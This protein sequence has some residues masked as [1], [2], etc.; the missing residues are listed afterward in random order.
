MTAKRSAGRDD[1][2]ALALLGKNLHHAARRVAVKRRK[3]SLEH[4]YSLGRPQINVRELALSVWQGRGNTI[5]IHTQA[6]HTKSRACAKAAYGQLQVLRLILAVTCRHA[7][8][9][10]QAFRNVELCPTV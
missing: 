1:R 2:A 10:R 6:A 3:R 7:R 8:H 4:F 9:Q 5:D